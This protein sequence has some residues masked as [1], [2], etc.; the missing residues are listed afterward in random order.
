MGEIYHTKT[1]IELYKIYKP[2][3]ILVNN[4]ELIIINEV[5]KNK[6]KLIYLVRNQS[7]IFIYSCLLF[8]LKCT[9][10]IDKIY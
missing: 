3:P 2:V 5:G 9:P 1:K 7:E 6:K 8:L 10:V 4:L